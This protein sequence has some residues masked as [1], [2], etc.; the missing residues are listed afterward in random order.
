MRWALDH[1]SVEHERRAPP[2]GLHMAVALWLTRGRSYTFPVLELDCGTYGDSSEIIAALEG[3]VPDPH[4]YPSDRDERRRALQLE[5][6]LGEDVFPHLRRAVWHEMGRHPNHFAEVAVQSAPRRIARFRRVAGAYGR[7]FTGLRYSARDAGRA[8]HGRE[9]IAEGMDRLEAELGP[10]EYLVGERFTVADLTAA[11][12]LY[13]LVLPPEGPVGPE[14]MPESW[15]RF[16]ARF[17]G[18]PGYRWVE[19][20]FARHRRSRS[21]S[22][23]QAVE[24]AVAR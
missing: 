15:H 17:E 18:R 22:G 21:G 11:A 13:P 7:A 2:P 6:W 4:L 9:K 20:M 24:P 3:T 12:L 14:L 19:R 10:N 23:E 8:A 16:R 1:K 5:E